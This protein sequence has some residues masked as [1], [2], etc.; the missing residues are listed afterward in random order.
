MDVRPLIL[1]R[2]ANQHPPRRI[3]DRRSMA[4]TALTGFHFTKTL[5]A[6]PVHCGVWL[7]RHRP[8]RVRLIRFFHP[9]AIADGNI[10]TAAFGVV[11]GDDIPPRKSPPKR[12]L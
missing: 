10:R 7:S 4:G 11:T 12:P 5:D 2:M 6:A 3:T 8:L 1:I 9:V